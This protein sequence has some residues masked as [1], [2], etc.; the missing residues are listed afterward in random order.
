[1]GFWGFGF[2]WG[3]GFS[4]GPIS[5]SYMLDISPSSK[6]V[7]GHVGYQHIPKVRFNYPY[8]EDT[9]QKGPLVLEDPNVDFTLVTIT[10][11]RKSRH[12]NTITTPTAIFPDKNNL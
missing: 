6:K 11:F 10:T 1:M 4:S 5:S 9:P 8:Y 3:L 12:R 2:F 7:S